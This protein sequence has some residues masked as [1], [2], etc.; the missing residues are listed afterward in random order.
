M[1]INYNLGILV[2]GAYLLGSVPFG[3]ILAKA[4]GV[5]LR[6]VGSGNI[7][8]TNVGRALGKKSAY[9]CFF[10]DA[11]KGA[12]PMVVGA[13]MIEEPVSVG[14]LWMWLL[15]GA[16]AVAGHIYPVYVHFK[17]GKGVATSLG[18]VLGLYPYYTFIGL[19]CFLIWVISLL[20]W[21][22]VSLSSIIAA[23]VFPV[24]LVLTI[25]AKQNWNFK[26]LYPLVIVSIIMGA[27]VIY[28]HRDNIE[29]LK[30]GTENK[31][32]NK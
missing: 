8:A 12:L 28:K 29:R 31:V 20:K 13:F 2:I 26:E 24:I 30:A 21:R 15:A 19:L 27:F 1:V 14:E 4:K 16:A 25:A 9:L 17:G 10:L 18:M 6:K 7:G 23:G 3:L 5:D 11:I 32:F 22:Y